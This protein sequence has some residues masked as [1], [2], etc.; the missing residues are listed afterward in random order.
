MSEGMRK[1]VRRKETGRATKHQGQLREPQS[2][3]SPAAPSGH[4]S[5]PCGCSLR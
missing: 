3:A 1:S 4:S 2:P 5:G